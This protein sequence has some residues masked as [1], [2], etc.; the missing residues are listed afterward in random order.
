[1]KR[2]TELG[3]GRKALERGS[4]FAA[5]SEGL[6]RTTASRQKP[7]PISPASP[8]QRAKVRGAISIVSGEGPCD[9]AHLWPRGMGGCDDPLCVV[10]LTRTEHMAFDAGALDL[11]P[12]LIAHGLW[13]ELAHMILA[14]H[15]DPIAMLHRTTGDRY[16]PDQGVRVAELEAEVARLNG[17]IDDAALRFEAWLD[18]RRVPAPRQRALHILGLGGDE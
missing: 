18:T 17:V 3:P 15:V 5:R 6:K 8:A 4:T 16:T 7:R 12:Y 9:P 1:M 14:H 13:A 2:T 11:Q 10:P